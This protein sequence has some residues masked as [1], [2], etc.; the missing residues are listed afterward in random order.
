MKFHSVMSYKECSLYLMDG[1]GVFLHQHRVCQSMVQLRT[2]Y[3]HIHGE[4]NDD[5]KATIYSICVAFSTIFPPVVSSQAAKTN[6]SFFSTLPV[7]IHSFV[8]KLLAEPHTTIR[9]PTERTG[10]PHVCYSIPDYSSM[11]ISYPAKIRVL[12]LML[13][14]V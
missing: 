8:L 6:L 12:S 1:L 2:P 9:T 14:V 13:L 7:A 5:F 10:R 4:G 11:K 3:F